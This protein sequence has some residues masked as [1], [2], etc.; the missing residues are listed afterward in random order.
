[1]TQKECV[2]KHL[3][4]GKTITSMQAINL[5]GATRLSGIIY[6]L[7]NDGHDIRAKTMTVKNRFG[8]CSNVSVYSLVGGD[9]N[10]E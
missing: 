2:L 4:E 8:H 9:N 1:M 10:A 5:Y 3:Q 6:F 7:R